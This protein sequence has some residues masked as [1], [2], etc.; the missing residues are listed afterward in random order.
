MRPGLD[1]E[2]SPTTGQNS[3]VTPSPTAAAAPP[4]CPSLQPPQ[5]PR[6]PRSQ[7]HP[8]APLPGSGLTAVTN[9]GAF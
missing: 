8:A 7:T 2:G 9:P 6:A 1:Q 4:A 5:H 3:P